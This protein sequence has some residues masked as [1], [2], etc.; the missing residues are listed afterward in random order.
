MIVY[1]NKILKI[2]INKIKK[3]YLIKLM[4]NNSVRIQLKH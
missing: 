1:N 3:K 4:I 2:Q